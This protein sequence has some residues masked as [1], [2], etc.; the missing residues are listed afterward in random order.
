MRVLVVGSGGRE[1]AIVWALSRSASVT[2]IV[3]APG[4]PGIAE[5]ADCSPEKAE[6]TKA[7][8]ELARYRRPDLVVIGPEAPLAAG[9]ADVLSE[10]F[11]VFGPRASGARLESSKSYAKGLMAAK[12]IP[13]AAS[14]SFRRPAEAIAYVRERGRPVVV[15]ADGLAAGKGVTVC[16][17]AGQAEAAIDQAM[18]GLRFGEA[19]RTILVEDRLFGQ[20]LSLLAFCDGKT[21]LPLQPAQDYKRAL[22]GDGGSNTGGMGS[23]SPVP[24][25]TPDVFDEA[26]QLVLEPI[27][28]ALA[29]QGETYVGVIYAGLMLTEG[30]LKVIEF[31]C[32]FGD[33]ET[34]ALLPRLKTDLGEVM[35]ACVDGALAGE[36]L[37]WSSE[38]CVTVVAASR[39]YPDKKGFP[40]GLPVTGLGDVGSGEDVLVFHS[41]TA[42]VEDRVVTAGGRVVSVSALGDDIAQARKKAYEGM[43]QISFPG[44]H[45]RTD[46]AAR[47]AVSIMAG[48]SH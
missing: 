7:L 39:G 21:V 3:C 47:A 12:A 19:G 17:N 29:E 4:N 32:R 36:S 40:T 37:D 30:G 20:E 45:Y 25:C 28:Q 23:Y 18:V 38:A 11:A 24:I 9:L 44:M 41:G 8:V 42:R 10:D 26:V 33:P 43:N 27:A 1:H 13:T 16:E 31:N 35:A 34:Q 15:K 2:E 5:L 22:D 6:D 14:A 46:I 48:D